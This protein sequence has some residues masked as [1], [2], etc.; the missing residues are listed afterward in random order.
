M[1]KLLTIVVL[2]VLLMHKS[3]AKETLPSIEV[4]E[5]QTIQDNTIIANSPVSKYVSQNGTSGI[6][7]NCVLSPL[8]DTQ[9]RDYVKDELDSHFDIIFSVEGNLKPYL[10]NEELIKKILNCESGFDQSKIGKAGEI[11]IAQYMP[12]TWEMFNKQRGTMLDIHS[13][14]DQVDMLDWALNNNL[15]YHWT[16]YRMIMCDK[17]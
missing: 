16:C 5:T 7:D 10:Y 12:T 4:Q 2:L 8:T 9:T 3:Y 11:G 1:K 6:E 14:K 15:G 17:M 13:E